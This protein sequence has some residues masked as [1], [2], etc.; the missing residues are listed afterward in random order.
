VSIVEAQLC[1]AGSYFAIGKAKR[2]LEY[3][4]LV[5]THE[6]LRR[7]AKDAREYYDSLGV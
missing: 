4:P 3:E 7:T 5:D 6:G 1:V 2:D